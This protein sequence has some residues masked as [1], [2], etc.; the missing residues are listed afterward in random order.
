M[1]IEII[2]I[3]EE[4]KVIGLSFKKLGLSYEAANTLEK[5]WDIYGEKYRYKVK[6]TIKPLVDY[7]INIFLPESKDEYIAGCAVRDINDLD[8]DW[9]SFV[10]PQGEY[11]KMSCHNMNNMGELFEVDSGNW[12]K[13]NG[14]KINGD[15]MIEMYPDGAFEGKDAEISILYPIQT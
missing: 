14:V 7:G 15:F 1:N 3:A 8:E 4:I 10:I 6:N 13:K 2:N 9:V 5:M 11:M 12:A